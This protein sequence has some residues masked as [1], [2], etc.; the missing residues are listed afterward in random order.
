MGIRQETYGEGSRLITEPIYKQI[1]AQCV[2]QTF[3]LVV[4]LLVGHLYIPES[5]DSLDEIIGP[6][7]QAK[8]SSQ[9]AATVANGLQLN[10][11][12]GTPSYEGYDRYGIFS[13]HLTIVFNIYSLMQIFNCLNCRR[14]RDKQINVLEDIE[15]QTALLLA[16]ALLAHYFFMVWG[17][18][19]ASL[20][21]QSLTLQQW[22][23]SAGLGMS[24]WL[25]G[26][27]VRLL[28]SQGRGGAERKVWGNKSYNLGVKLVVK[29][30][31]LSE[32]DTED[33]LQFKDQ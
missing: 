26:F 23:I 22:L 16:A 17:P 29:K 32:F 1:V 13:R 8:Y 12:L 20:Y 6:N 3:L 18:S 15:P 19:V 25:V 31:K 5:P 28:P 14:I 27:L 24:V 2:F 30:N 7:W 10:P 33:D 21:P 11:L 9:E 4:V